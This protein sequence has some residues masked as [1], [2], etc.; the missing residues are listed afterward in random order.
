MRAEGITTMAANVPHK[1]ETM[2]R[3]LRLVSWRDAVAL[4][5]MTMAAGAALIVTALAVLR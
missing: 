2:D 3:D 1:G 5:A 4:W